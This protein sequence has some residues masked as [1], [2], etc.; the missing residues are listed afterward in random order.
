MEITGKL[1]QVMGEQS[2]EGKNGV[3][4][5]LSF[6]IETQEQYPKKVCIDAWNDRID[7]IKSCSIND[8]IKV[9]FDIESREFNGKWY[10]NLKAWKIEK[11]QSGGGP[12][13]GNN[14]PLPEIEDFSPSS[15]GGFVPT[16]D[17]PF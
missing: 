11:M 16:D 12:Q 13:A 2:G 17:L 5:K 14:P 4:K 7:V 3:W 6:V 9:D 8:A 1:S 10:T 15:S